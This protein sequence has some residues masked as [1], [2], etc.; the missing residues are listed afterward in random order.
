VSQTTLDKV[1]AEICAN[2]VNYVCGALFG[3][4]QHEI[5]WRAGHSDLGYLRQL[6]YL[7]NYCDMARVVIASLMGSANF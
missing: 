6:C 5:L 7:K 3:D 4:S 2:L 1:L